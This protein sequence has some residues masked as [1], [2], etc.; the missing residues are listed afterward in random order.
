MK[1]MIKNKIEEWISKE[2]YC[3][4]EVLYGKETIYSI[5]TNTEQPYIKI[6]AYRNCIVICTSRDLYTRLRTLLKDKN[7]DEIFEFPFVYGQTIHYVPSDK[8]MDT[9]IFNNTSATDLSLNNIFL[10]SDYNCEF[11]F[12]EEIFSLRGLKGFDNSL[13]FDAKGDTPTKALFIVK[14][15]EKIIGVAG[16]AKT[17]VDGVYEIGVDVMEQHRNAGLGSYLV[18]RL[19]QGLL[20]RNIVPFYSAS[21]TNI[22]SQM[23]ANRCGYMPL[24]V[25]TYGTTLDGSSVYNNIVSELS[26]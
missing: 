16:A 5:N 10:S 1:D 7:R 18:S 22:G 14:D 13:S 19:T 25:D 4:I 21:V 8:Y 3:S 26:L 17:A 23:V 12:D 9:A 2:Y 20:A 24:W 15:N 6:M 11:L